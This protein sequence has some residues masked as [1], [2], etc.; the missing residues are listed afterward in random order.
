[1]DCWMPW[2]TRLAAATSAVACIAKTPVGHSVA[3]RQPQAQPAAFRFPGLWHSGEEG[4]YLFSRGAPGGR[5]KVRRLAC[6]G[7][8]D[9]EVCLSKTSPIALWLLVQAQCAA[10]GTEEQKEAGQPNVVAHPIRGRE[11]VGY[12]QK[13]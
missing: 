2:R 7:R 11:H 3:G 1:M 5:K 13:N 6:R 10:S 9:A 8:R 12:P 4:V